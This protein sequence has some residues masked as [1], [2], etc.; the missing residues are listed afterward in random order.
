MTGYLLDTNVASE[1]TR[2]QPSPVVL[3]FL[4]R[5]RDLWLSAVSLHEFSYGAA[6]APTAAR[7][8]ELSTWIVGIKAAFKSRFIDVDPDIAERAGQLR[9]LSQ[10]RGHPPSPTDALIAACAASRGPTIATR[11]TKDFRL[12]GLPLI[13]PWTQV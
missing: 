7:R 6:R 4:N 9:A 1:P 5:E 13:D 10:S 8:L 3:D 11:N 12:F 2:P